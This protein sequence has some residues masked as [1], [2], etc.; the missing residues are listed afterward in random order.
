[1]KKEYKL[2]T[3]NQKKLAEFNRL[4]Q[5][6]TFS[7]EEGR[8]LREIKCDDHF[9]VAIHKAL[10][11][12]ENCVVEDTIL[13]VDYRPVTDIRY[14][15]A[16]LEAKTEP[17]RLYWITTLAVLSDGYVTLYSAGIKGFFKPL[18][19]APKDAFGFDPYFVPDGSDKTLYELENAGE[20]DNYSARKLVL[21]SFCSNNYRFRKEA[22]QIAQWTGNYQE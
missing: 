7:I 1:M 5:G 13:K 20:K 8:D 9:L 6:Q 21:D 2:V 11:A 10:E 16:E 19:N 3:S 18:K 14:K 15:L 17:C 22:S 4:A 12:G